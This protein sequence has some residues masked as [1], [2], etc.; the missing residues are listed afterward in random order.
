[1]SFISVIDLEFWDK[2]QDE[3]ML[4][5]KNCGSCKYNYDTS[6]ERNSLYLFK[7]RFEYS[8]ILEKYPVLLAKRIW[9]RI[10][11]LWRKE[12]VFWE[13]MKRKFSRHSFHYELF[14]HSRWYSLDKFPPPPETI[15]LTN[16]S[17]ADTLEL[18][19]RYD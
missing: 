7:N 6:I 2:M 17:G 9:N 18:R 16:T 1:M 13:G 12:Q 11:N 19:K 5:T 4:K 10:E 14:P 8:R 3:K 15:R